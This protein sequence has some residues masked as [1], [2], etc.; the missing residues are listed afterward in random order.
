MGGATEERL[1]TPDETARYLGTSTGY[2]KKCRYAKTGPPYF[3][4]GSLVRYHPAQVKRWLVANQRGFR[5][6]TIVAKK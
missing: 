3:K 5:Q 2:L 1:W 4:L 6:P